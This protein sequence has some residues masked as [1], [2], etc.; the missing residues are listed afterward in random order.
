MGEA[1]T[2][3]SPERFEPRRWLKQS[4]GGVLLSGVVVAM[5]LYFTV[6][7]ADW[8]PLL[9]FPPKMALLIVGMVCIAWV[10][11]GLRTWVLAG[12]FG[13]RLHPATAVGITLSMEFVIAASPGGVGGWITRAYLQRRVGIPISTTV[14]MLGADVTADI[15]FF[16]LL[17]PLAVDQLLRLESV[18]SVLGQVDWPAA[19]LLAVTVLLF[20]ALPVVFRQGTA[21][22]LRSRFGR[23]AERHDSW[24]WRQIQRIRAELSQAAS[25]TLFLFQKRRFAF[26]ISCA[27]ATL[28]WTCRYGILPVVLWGLGSPVHPLALMLVQGSLFLVGLLVV[29]PGGGGSLE[30]LTVLILGP[31]VGPSQAALAVVIW[32]AATY[33]LYILGGGLTFLLVI[34]QL[35]ATGR[36]SLESEDSPESARNGWCPENRH[37]PAPACRKKAQ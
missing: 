13:H 5:V 7:Q 16:L 35:G 17:T 20:V 36:A 37:A 18:R 31:M 30:I 26:F 22:W 19:M 12:A 32:R 6:D 27:F 21:G 1:S 15:L 10:C 9:E 25:S 33:Y 11:N 28:Q 3:P 29:A 4:L 2:D 24:V 34:K 14:S 23:S 8:R